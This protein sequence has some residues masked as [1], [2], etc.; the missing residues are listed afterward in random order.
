MALEILA[1]RAGDDL[2]QT[3]PPT[4]GNTD[5]GQ[6]RPTLPAFAPM[7]APNMGSIPP[8]AIESVLDFRP[9]PPLALTSAEYADEVNAVQAIG[10]VGSTTRTDYQ[11]G[12]A[13]F[14]ASTATI[15]WNKAAASAS[16]DRNLTLSDNAR[17]FAILNV[18]GAD[19]VIVC[20]DSK[21]YYNF[22]RPI[23]AIQLADTDDNPATTADTRMAA[24]HQHAAVSGLLFRPPE[25]QRSRRVHPDRVLRRATGERG[26]RGPDAGHRAQLRILRRGG[27]RR[28][29]GAVL[30]GHPLQLHA[31]C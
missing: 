27:R 15:F 14:W 3:V 13:R 7:S 10:A 6:W 29:A 22:W 11:T 23:T 12:S 28:D 30:V 17:L 31:S 9:G 1:W 2:A 24:A 18:A 19:A 4:T 26:L 21:L 8:F 16:R 5:P 20:W 25:W